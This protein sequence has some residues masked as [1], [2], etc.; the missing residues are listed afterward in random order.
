MKKKLFIL[1]KFF[2]IFEVIKFEKLNI[3]DIV[4]YFK[5][6]FIICIL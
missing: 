3:I 1:V 5:S 2:G 4:K 6:Y